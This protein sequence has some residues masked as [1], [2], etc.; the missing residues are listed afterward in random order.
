[1]NVGP[2]PPIA[3]VGASSVWL[4]PGPWTLLLDFLDQRFPRV[5]REVWRQR[6]LGGRV[7]DAAGR[8]LS[9]DT[10]YAVGSVVHYYRDVV[11]EPPITAVARILHRDA[12]LLVADKPHFLPT[13]PA[14]RFV[15]QSL[16]VRLKLETGIDTLVPLHRLDRGTA[17]LVLFSADPATR[18]VY[19]ELFSGRGIVKEYEALAPRL[20]AGAFP[21]RRR[22][23]IVRGEPF[24]RMQEIDGEANAETSVELVETCGDVGRYRL[25]P[26]TGRKHQLR[27]HMAALGA[28]ILNDRWYPQLQADAPDDLDRPLQL[29]ARR[30]A[31]ID[32]LSGAERA[33]ESGFS[34]AMPNVI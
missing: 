30:L 22:S 23:R 15:Q 1:M 10:R 33:F 5:G 25:L 31:F 29:L 11:D 9:A 6:L 17:G 18:A 3:G 16:L 14:G 28:A 26:V 34:L 19:S 4:P 2:L 21:L 7:H 8:S 32:P 27:V 13:M 24:F 12:H 20:P